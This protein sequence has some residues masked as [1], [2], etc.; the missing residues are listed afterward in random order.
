MEVKEF[1]QKSVAFGLGTAAFG[2]EKISQF[3]DEM[4][5]RG[6][7]SSE[8]AKKIIDDASKRAVE[9]K[10]KLKAWVSE[11]VTKLHQQTGAAH[12]EKIAGLEA[13]IAE[14]E[15]KLGNPDCNCGDKAAE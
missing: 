3:A 5:K 9:E 11:Q 10:D 1:L 8:D 12:A 4:V 15:K 6:E 13:R 14:L 2:A 7:L